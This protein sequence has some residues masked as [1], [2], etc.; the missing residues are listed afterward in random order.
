MIATQ[1][2]GLAKACV[3]STLI[4]F[5]MPAFAE[6]YVS[7]YGSDEGCC[8]P[9]PPPCAIVHHRCIVV[10][11]RCHRIIRH[12]RPCRRVRRPAC[13][14][15]CAVRPRRNCYSIEV[16]PAPCPCR[17]PIWLQPDPYTE[18]Y[19]SETWV[20]YN[21]DRATADDN[22]WINPGMNIDY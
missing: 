10:K 14:C 12:K 5:T 2:S 19:I 8:P 7:Y 22:A 21:P 16:R 20:S 17:G 4:C 18:T 15:P 13:P 9:P 3:I 1:L 6:Y 11:P